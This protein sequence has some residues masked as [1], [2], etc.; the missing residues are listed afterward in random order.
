MIAKEQKTILLVED[1]LT[2]SENLKELLELKNYKVIPFNTIIDASE[3]LNSFVPDLIISD[4]VMPDFDGY[5]LISKIKKHPVLQFV[6]FIFISGKVEITDIR[7]GMNHGADDYIT[8]PFTAKDLYEAIEVRINNRRNFVH[9]NS[10][11]LPVDTVD[12]FKKEAFNN[13]SKSELVIVKL[14]AQNM[15]SDEISSHLGISRKTVEN[16]RFNIAKKLNLRGKLSLLRYCLNNPS[17]IT[18]F[19]RS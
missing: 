14:I 19:T 10:A 1:D 18:S 8:K 3:F 11:N 4:I 9:N 13:L 17:A 12:E 16:H 2:L 7:Y 5:S 6:P 15:T